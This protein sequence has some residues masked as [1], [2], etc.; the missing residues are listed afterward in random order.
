MKGGRIRRTK[1]V[2][3]TLLSPQVFTGGGFF[4]Q[5]EDITLQLGRI[6]YPSSVMGMALAWWVFPE[7]LQFGRWWGGMGF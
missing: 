1:D 5:R 3:P 2:V 4:R 6:W 7:R